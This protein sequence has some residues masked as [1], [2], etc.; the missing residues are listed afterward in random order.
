[1]SVIIEKLILSKHGVIVIFA[2]S[3]PVKQE[4]AA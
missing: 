2:T 1:M 3:I 4:H